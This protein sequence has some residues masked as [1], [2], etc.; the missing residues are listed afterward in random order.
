MVL[1]LD[2]GNPNSY[3]PPRSDQYASSLVLA[4]PMNGANNGTTFTDESAIIK[5]SGTA[6]A[7][8]SNGS[9]QTLTAQS[10][11]YG[12]S[13]FFNNGDSD[14]LTIPATSDLQV[15]AGTDFTVE[16]WVYVTSYGTYNNVISK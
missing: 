3:S 5:G 15:S 11:F 9:T 1:N 7:I 16:M 2:A 12:S 8:T 10:K 13:G 14:N 6:K 4:V